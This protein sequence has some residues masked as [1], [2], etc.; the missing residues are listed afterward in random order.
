ME[1]NEN[2][3]LDTSTMRGGGGSGGKIAV[4]G[5]GGLIILVLS[6]ILGINPGSLLGGDPG[7]Q[8]TNTNP[9][10]QCTHGSDIQKNRQCRFTAYT[11]SINDYWGKTLQGYQR[12]HAQ[13]F[14]GSIN[15]ACGTATAAVGPFYCP[16]DQ[17]VYL[18]TD[19]F[20]ELT[21]KFGA[22]GGEAAEAYVI[23]HEFGHHISNLTGVMD[24]V[25]QQG[26]S[27]G[28]TSNSVRLELQADCYAGVW[29]RN[30]TADPN[31]PIKS[32]SQDDLD[33]AVDAARAVGDDR[34]QRETTGR[35]DREAWTHG[36]S[37]QRKRWLAT[38]YNSGNPRSCDTFSATTL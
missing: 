18:D 10:A 20:N 21:S 13:D 26:N 38:G 32:V 15:T 36:S 6:L 19:F 23:A 11:T 4:G 7:E 3:Q 35:V 27:T 33:R 31:S 2:A 22:R 1:F 9:Y 34:I 14:K 16:G 37:E 17:I 5:I 25:Q 24:R 30:A 12:T 29:L 8:Q 28:P